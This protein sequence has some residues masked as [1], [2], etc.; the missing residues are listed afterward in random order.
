MMRSHFPKE[1]LIVDSPGIS[2][3]VAN[4]IMEAWPLVGGKI[5]RDIPPRPTKRYSKI[6]II[7]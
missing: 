2:S 3:A 6:I 4:G 5:D 1:G 7:E